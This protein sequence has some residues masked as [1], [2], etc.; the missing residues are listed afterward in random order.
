MFV[1]TQNYGDRPTFHFLNLNWITSN[2]LKTSGIW[3]TRQ[4]Y[5]MVIRGS[6]ISTSWTVW[7]CWQSGIPWSAWYQPSVSSHSCQVEEINEREWNCL[8][9]NCIIFSNILKS[10]Y[11]IQLSIGKVQHPLKAV[12]SLSPNKP[13][14]HP[15]TGQFSLFSLLWYLIINVYPG[16]VYYRLDDDSVI[17]VVNFFYPSPG[18]DSFFWAGENGGCDEDSIGKNSY[19]LSPG[20][21]GSEKLNI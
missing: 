13:E 20:K 1:V 9:L 14:K 15:L 21:V 17:T 2:I 5:I 6:S 8:K 16:D 12:A 19:P 11:R 10:C 7:Q 3:L 4:A 18:P